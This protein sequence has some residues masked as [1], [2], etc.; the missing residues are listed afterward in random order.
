MT[1]LDY[2]FR[3]V[4]EFLAR[5][6]GATTE[7]WSW[8]YQYKYLCTLWQSGLWWVLTNQRP[9]ILTSDQS[10]AAV[11]DV[12]LVTSWQHQV[13]GAPFSW[14]ATVANTNIVYIRIDQQVWSNINVFT[15]LELELLSRHPSIMPEHFYVLRMTGMTS[16]KLWWF[17]LRILDSRHLLELAG[18]CSGWAGLGSSQVV[19]LLLLSVPQPVPAAGALQSGERRRANTDNI[20]TIPQLPLGAGPKTHIQTHV[21][22]LKGAKS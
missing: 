19:Q 15:K 22:L 8:L 13:R 1:V 20:V 4:L 12:V 17:W 18:Q 11:D 9:G 21:I 16:C 5:H 3:F 6:P 2:T 10:E 14:V 7:R